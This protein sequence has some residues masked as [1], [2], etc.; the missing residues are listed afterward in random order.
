MK[1]SSSKEVRQAETSQSMSHRT[2]NQTKRLC[3]HRQLVKL[4]ISKKSIIGLFIEAS[5]ERNHRRTI[6]I[7][8][9]YSMAIR[10][11]AKCS[12]QRPCLILVSN[13]NVICLYTTATIMRLLGISNVKIWD[14]ISSSDFWMNPD[15]LMIY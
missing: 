9:A 4:L 7:L 14:K 1:I 12:N 13:T 10:D 5:I 8:K 15:Y 3:Y 6:M 11:K 2:M